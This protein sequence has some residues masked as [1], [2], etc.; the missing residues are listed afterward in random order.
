[1]TSTPELP[2]NSVL[3]A[4]LEAINTHSRSVLI[5]APGAGKTTRVPLALLDAPWL[6]GQKILMLEPRRVAARLAA[7]FMA[8]QLGESVGQRVGYRVRMES[9]VSA[10]T[11][12]EVVTQGVLTRMLQD[13]PM[14]EGVGMVIF[15]EFHER[16]LQS[17]LGLA[18]LMDTQDGLRDD[19]KLLVMSATLEAKPLLALLG[20]DTPLVESEGRQYPVTTHYL[21]GDKN[22]PLEQQIRE[23]V[24]TALAAASGDIL[25]FL[26]GLREIRRASDAL[27]VV[28][29]ISLQPLYGGLTLAEQQAALAPDAQGRR[30]VVLSTS[31]AESSLTVEDVRIVIDAGLSRE[32]SFDARSGFTRL[33]TRQVSQA[34][35]DQRRGRAGRLGPGVCYRLWQPHAALAPASTPEIR[36]TD[37]ADLLL[38]LRLW[39]VQDHQSLRWLTPPPQGAWLQAERLLKQLGL[40]T[41]EGQPSGKAKLCASLGM[42][43]RAM[44]MQPES[45]QDACARGAL[46]LAAWLQESERLP[47]HQDAAEALAQLANSRLPLNQRL[48]RQVDLW[49]KK[50]HIS[51]ANTIHNTLN[52]TDIAALL[53]QAFPDRIGKQVSLGTFATS[54]GQ[55]LSIASESDLAHAP[56]LVILDADGK[57]IYNAAALTLEQIN[58]CFP[59][60]LDWQLHPQWNASLQKPEVLQQRRLGQLVLESKAGPAPTTEQRTAALLEAIR[61][62]GLLNVMPQL[63]P[64]LDRLKF[65][66]RDKQTSWPEYS[67]EALEATLEDWLQPYMNTITRLGGL[68]ELSLSTL[69]Q[70][71]LGWDK[72]QQVN[73]LLPLSLEVP[74][75]S[76]ITLD[77][78]GDEP[79]LAARLQE[80]FGQLETPRLLNGQLPVLVHLLSPA[81]RP[82]QVTRDLHNFWKNTYFEVKKDLKGRYP[83]HY[84]PE[85]PMTA[86]AISGVRPRK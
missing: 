83:K 35:A 76:N 81:R 77:Y 12:I 43:A 57:R 39:G 15:D 54:G 32:P 79:V 72:V 71:I 67:A 85:D 38:E 34:S 70:S 10:A 44:A 36:S 59:T 1:M 42:S 21:P 68:T 78:S 52:S 37:L 69:A 48:N 62:Q 61:Q 86:E 51:A 84:W 26:P 27:S 29:N 65:L 75:G 23:A 45:A 73:A 40:L 74:S 41:E 11:Q 53:A 6:S 64:L 8:E 2:I 47:Q 19:L 24:E 17:D 22:T 46:W 82:I 33:E 28:A 13:D 63:V 30:K 58:T 7:T 14:L 16:A 5:A 3:P 49:A 55:R 66:P 9:K 80:L 18:L 56:W 4:L 25:V 60:T 50:R 31:L 20:D